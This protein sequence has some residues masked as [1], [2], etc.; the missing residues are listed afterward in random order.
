MANKEEIRGLIEYLR[1][2]PPEQY[3]QENWCGAACCIAGHQAHRLGWVPEEVEKGDWVTFIEKDGE[4]FGPARAANIARES[5]G[6]TFNE[7]DVLFGPL[8]KWWKHTDEFRS[9][10]SPAERLTIAI[11]E[12]ETYL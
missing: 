7:A 1:V 6:L 11:K 3:D 12:L 10:A 2:L 8:A 4:R 9:A 5:L